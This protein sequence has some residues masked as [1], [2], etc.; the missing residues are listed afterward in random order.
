[1]PAS[2]RPAPPRGNHHFL[3]LK[4][5]GKRRGL[6]LTYWDLWLLVVL[7][8]DF[9][10]DWE[11]LAKRFHAESGALSLRRDSVEGLLNHLRGLRQRLA[12]AGVSPASALGPDGPSLLKSERRRARREI[13]E[14]S[15]REQDKSA[16]MRHTPR[17]EREDRA[18]RGYWSRF[19]VSP[20]QYAGVLERLFK[21]AGYYSEDQS[22][23][24]QRQ[25]SDVLQRQQAGATPAEEAALCRAFLT[26]LLQKMDMIDD[27]Y[28]V[29][30]DLY[31]EL[32]EQYCQVGRVAFAGALSNFF[33]D[34]LEFMLWE[35]Y[36][37]GYQ[38]Q[39]AFFA[40]LA[41]P[42]AEL[43]ESILRTQWHELSELALEYQSEKALTLLG[44]LCT[45][46]KQFDKFVDLARQMGSRQWERITSMSAMAEKHRR[47]ALAQAVY[48]ASLGPGQHETYLRKQYAE[49][50]ERLQKVKRKKP[51]P[52]K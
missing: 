31:G 19:P 28:G 42:E 33:Q 18:R 14:K 34:L 48:E 10:G 46:Q 41:P 24:L 45:R 17:R 52:R 11:Q 32:F 38:V 3:T 27:S 40:S 6:A 49:F 29:I 5:P 36:G 50:Q 23:G 51:S 1:M 21:T 43:V 37:F 20:G 35:D 26:V 25:L 16:R 39:P 12:K 8:T 9:A 4:V 22:F 44:V 15:P 13:L 30:G 7:L 2:P 47:Y